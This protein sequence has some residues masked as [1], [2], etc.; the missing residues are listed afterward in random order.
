M[1]PGH[2]TPTTNQQ[3]AAHLDMTCDVARMPC[4]SNNQPTIISLLAATSEGVIT[5]EGG[6]GQAYIRAALFPPH[7][8]GQGAW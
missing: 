3:S 2:K 8:G 4:H 1:L 6:V 7:D 5:P